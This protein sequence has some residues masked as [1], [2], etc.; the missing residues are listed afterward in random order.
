MIR[1]SSIGVFLLVTIS[2]T[3]FAASPL[4]LT[5]GQLELEV[6][7]E[8]AGRIT[9]LRLRGGENILHSGNAS[10]TDTSLPKLIYDKNNFLRLHGHIVW[11][12][13][14]TEWW[15]QQDAEKV[16]RTESATWPPDPY[17]EFSK[18]AIVAQD[19]YHVVLRSNHSPFSGVTM[20]KEVRLAAK[21]RVLLKTTITNTGDHTVKW[22]IW[23][24]TCIS[25]NAV[26]YVQPQ[27][28]QELRFEFSSWESPQEQ[29]LRFD[30]WEELIRF[31]SV[32]GQYIPKNGTLA[33]K[34]FLHPLRPVIIAFINGTVFIKKTT[35][36]A[37]S[38]IAPGH[39]QIEIFGKKYYSA[40]QSFYE[41]EFH[42]EY[43]NLSPGC[44]VC[45]EENWILRSGSHPANREEVLKLFKE[46]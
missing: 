28:R 39:R 3:A 8:Q 6:R 17:W 23:S 25:G 10:L 29:P 19:E 41:L 20:T 40:A 37:A 42:G 44:S 27:P 14:Q 5:N 35:A 38:K 31:P 1:Q 7:P 43:V 36:V 11:L 32:A 9:S 30:T 13:P 21:D 24:N 15:Q 18:F 34:L 16:P 4:H 26:V 33:G 45:L 46:I 12:S 2:I 22:G